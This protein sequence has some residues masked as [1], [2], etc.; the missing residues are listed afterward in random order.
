MECAWRV[1]DLP[2]NTVAIARAGPLIGP[3]VRKVKRSFFAGRERLADMGLSRGRN[4][5]RALDARLADIARL[6]DGDVACAALNLKTGRMISLNGTLRVPMASV[7]KIPIAV[8]L[9][10]R[11]DRGEIALDS[12]IPVDVRDTRPGPGVL[13]RRMTAAGLSVSVKELVELM[14]TISDNTASD[15]AL[16]A[17]GGIEAARGL[18]SELKSVDISIDRSIGELLADMEGID[19]AYGACSHNN[20]RQVTSALPVGQRRRAVQKLLADARDTCTA[21]SIVRLLETIACGRAL[22]P[23]S[24]ALLL[25]TMTQ[26]KTAKRRLK[27]L[28]PRGAR[29]AHKTGSLISSIDVRNDRPFLIADVGLVDMDVQVSLACAVF[30]AGSPHEWEIQDRIVARLARTMFDE[31]LAESGRCEPRH[32]CVAAPGG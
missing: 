21:E 31:F 11:V 25:D 12:L 2:D 27:G 14:L 9:L 7:V 10:S 3:I 17:A 19:H 15:V 26:C 20:W 24:T 6:A 30:I 8:Q 1:Y 23:A 29:V 22:T 5:A 18:L 16:R 4:D 13:S 32:S 28:L